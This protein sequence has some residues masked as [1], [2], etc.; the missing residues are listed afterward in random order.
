[1]VVYPLARSVTGCKAGEGGRCATSGVSIRK[2]D[3]GHDG[4]SHVNDQARR[5]GK[6]EMLIGQK[7]GGWKR[8]SNRMGGQLGDNEGEGDGPICHLSLRGSAEP[9]VGKCDH[10]ATWIGR[11]CSMTVG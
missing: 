7:R 11:C 6:R 4:W 5:M 1:M 3:L 9:R 10:H 8:H 2:E